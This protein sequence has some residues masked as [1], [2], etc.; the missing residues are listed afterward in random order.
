MRGRPDPPHWGG[1][2][3]AYRACSAG[4]EQS[5]IDL[6]DATPGSPAPL[7]FRYRRSTFELHDDG[8][9]VQANASPGSTLSAGGV[10][11][12]LLQFHHHAPSE[13][14]V[15]GRSFAL[16]LH[17]VN[18]SDSG[19]LLVLG[20]LV[21]SGR[22][23]PAFDRLIAALPPRAGE[24]SMLSCFDPLS[25]L[26]DAGRG[27]RYAYT[28]SLTTPPCTEGVL[29]NVFASPLELS[30]AQIRRLASDH[31]RTNRPLQ[32]RNGR[33]LVLGGA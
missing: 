33:T 20:V 21:R 32:P 11:Y 31:E 23:H 28:G 12:Q 5:P 3:P 19:Q 4:R 9:S 13:H 24:H 22:S 30:A 7:H 16:E 2:D 1:L 15:E 25:L 6:A 10:A 27:A 17:L 14:Q 29:W 26:P 8:R 18:R